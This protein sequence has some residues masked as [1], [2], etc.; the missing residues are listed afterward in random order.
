MGKEIIK[1]NLKLSDKISLKYNDREVDMSLSDFK[2]FLDANLE[3]SNALLTSNEPLKYK[4]LIS[5][6]APIASTNSDT[7]LAGQIWELSGAANPSDYAFFDTY[8][9]ISGTLYGAGSKYRVSVDT[10]FTFSASA[11]EY[12]GSP[13]IVSTNADGNLNPSRNTTGV[14]AT[15][16]YNSAGDLIV[17]MTG[18]FADKRKVYHQLGSPVVGGQITSVIIDA[19]NLGI[20]TTNADG[21]ASINSLLYYTLIS[22]E[23]YP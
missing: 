15:F 4:A 22:I 21:T 17:T 1:T 6:N 19:D 8:E 3:P 14:D 10:P 5:Q 12:D 2:T 16:S 23:V 7:M 11:I 20:A 9:L 13:Y 18:L